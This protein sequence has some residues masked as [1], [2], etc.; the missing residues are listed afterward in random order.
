MNAIAID[1]VTS[2]LSVTAYGPKGTV[3]TA[4]TGGG[5]HA[6]AMLEVV[7]TTIARAG[8]APRET[9]LVAVPEGPGSFT[10]LRL[11]WAAAKALCFSANCPLVPVPTL[12]AY[13]SRF[14]DWNGPVVAVLD[15]KKSR[16]Y[17]RIFRRGVAVTEPMD[18]LAGEL[19][20]FLDPE[21]RLLVTGPDASLFTEELSGLNPL[22]SC[23][24]L[25]FGETGMSHELLL[26]AR[27]FPEGYTKNMADHIGPLYVRRSD[28]EIE[29][30]GK[31]N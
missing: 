10:G 16:F 14:S 23:L 9:G 27:A 8:F 12:D 13:A 15:A 3:T 31:G 1:T 19:G 20:R 25:P 17:A 18:I 28:A 2:A 4:V 26:L 30:N 21:D 7:E 29:F 5:Q 22:L 24:S 6:P 11:A